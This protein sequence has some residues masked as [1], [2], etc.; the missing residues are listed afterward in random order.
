MPAEDYS[1]VILGGR[2]LLPS[3]EVVEED[4]AVEGGRIAEIGPAATAALAL[5]ARDLLVL[6]GMIDLHGDSFERL[7]LPRPGMW[8]PL[9]VALAEAD[10]QFVANGVTT[11]FLA[12]GYSWEGGL[13][14]PECTEALVCWLKANR[15]R[16]RSDL[17]IHIRYEVFHVEGV[18]A[19]LEWLE[20]RAVDLLVFNDHLADY[21]ARL[22]DPGRLSFWAEKAGVAVPEFSDRI[23]TVR[24]REGE[25]PAV[26]QRLSAAAA[27][28]GV[29]A[30]S[31]DDPSPEVRA[32]FAALGATVAEFPLDVAT[33]SAA[34]ELGNP[35]IMGAPNV[36]RGGSSA[37][38]VAAIDLVDRGL[39]TALCS[40]YFVPA[41]LHAVFRIVREGI[42]P[43]AQAWDL[44]AGGPARVAGLGDRGA[45]TPGL[46][47]DLL[48]VDDRDPERPR[49][50]A[51]VIGGRIAHASGELL[52]KP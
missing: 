4:L 25:V 11:A 27:A 31:H 33:A 44:V 21:E 52:A 17:R 28:A 37:G 2:V 49:V 22:D 20:T 45:I 14:G 26:I 16:L 5:S 15:A 12:Q 38:H 36:V 19:A 6:P 8:F 43:F 1:L 32:R 47:G 10:R 41:M 40:D 50:A 30:G 34:L 13:R 18:D 42:M 51:T 46:R 48:I 9:D 29:V 23:R 39:C 7:I 24:A 3:G 35:V